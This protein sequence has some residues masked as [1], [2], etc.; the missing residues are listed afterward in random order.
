MADTG[1]TWGNSSA[2]S[3]GAG[4]SGITWDSSSQQSPQTDFTPSGFASQYSDAIS[5]AAS[6]LNVPAS[7]IA[8]QWGLET[9]WGKS[10]IPGTNNL[11]NLKSTAATGN[12]VAATDNATGS[13]DAYQQFQNPMD[14]S[15]AYVNLINKQYPKAVGAKDAGS[16]ATALKQGGYATDPNYVSSV[17][18]AANVANK[19]LAAVS[20]STSA[21]AASQD[22][23]A[24]ASSSV[25][26]FIKQVGTG[27]TTTTPS[28]SPGAPSVDDFI[29]QSGAPSSDNLGSKLQNVWSSIKNIPSEV[30]QG[31]SQS[32][33]HPLDAAKGVAASVWNPLINAFSGQTVADASQ[34]PNNGV[35]V[36]PQSLAAQQAVTQNANITPNANTNQT[37][38]NAGKFVGN[39]AVAGAVGAVAPEFEGASLLGRMAAPVINGGVQGGIQGGVT[40][41]MDGDSLGNVAAN[42]GLGAVGGAALGPV[43]HAIGAAVKPVIGA[44][45]GTKAGIAAADDAATKAGLAT[46]GAL[47]QSEKDMAG[48]VATAIN[49]DATPQTAQDVAA[50]MAANAN[51]TV[52][53]YQRT[54][55]ETTSNPTVQAIQQGLDKSDN[56]AGLA[57]QVDANANANTNFLR[58]GATS[59]ADLAAQKQSFQD[60]QDALANQGNA[61]MPPVS[62]ADAGPNGLFG[63][64]AMQKTLG[65]ANNAA[66]NDGSDA[67]QQAF[68]APNNAMAD[69]WSN[70]LAGSDAKTAAIES[71]RAMTTSPMYHDALSSAGPIA[72]DSETANLINT[73]AMQKALQGVETY[74]GNTLDDAPV[75]QNVP[76][77]GAGGHTYAQS[78]SPQDLNLAKMALDDHIMNMG[79]PLHIASAD[80]WQRGAYINLRNQVNAKLENHVPGFK[81]ANM[82]F[83]K[84]SDQM[85]ESQFLTNKNMV[86]ATGKMNV[87]Q[88]DA[89][90]KAIEAGK[91]NNNPH[92]PA[93]LVS[94]A[95]LAQ[96]QQMR[97]DAVSMMKTKSAEGLQGD[98]YNYL[99]QGAQQDPI[100]AQ[101]LQEHLASQ[102]PAYHQF[103]ND[104]AAGTHAI[105]QQEN[106]NN[107]VSKFDTRT[108]GNVSWHDTKNLGTDHADYSP[109]N[110]A[111]L[112]AVRANQERFANRT[113]QV[114]GSDT[115]SNFAKREGFQNLIAGQ[116]GNGI[117]NALMSESGQR[118]VRAGLGPVASVAGFSHAGPVGA[119]AADWLMDKAGSGIAKFA[120]KALGADTEEALAAKA[121]ANHGAVEKLLLNPK[122]LSDAISALDTSNKTKQVLT[123]SLISKVRGVQHLGGLL[124]AVSAGQVAA[125]SSNKKNKK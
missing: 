81:E 86:D 117:G 108:D 83:A 63:A 31:I 122:R 90:V 65:R 95:K 36:T 45:L 77:V 46:G 47:S 44:Y 121:A 12:G 72:L 53:G 112:N 115:A 55:A 8:G 111:R 48:K 16:F 74:K 26:S 105:G 67:I 23:T 100:A 102:S 18:S 52:P 58:Q 10:V 75:I 11:G 97:A 37:A 68:D 104:Q 119:V 21:N 33:Q 9:G 32:A 42:T 34:A 49:S 43:A 56:N 70:S 40:S 35:N 38:F 87:R 15:N 27:P 62:A 19:A 89:T 24:P 25:D 57:A 61:Q 125:N 51:S 91:A 5:N 4:S 30:G 59:D 106:Y 13:T 110:V 2:D 99:R 116:R 88:L 107:L 114:A 76:A 17:S 85:N 39:T 98:S 94:A 118:A 78:I 71:A 73:P 79:N 54:A 93:K 6:Q 3:S 29:K 82:E 109:E 22:S 80:K 123:D 84:R 113:E 7:A 28:V 92:D 60:S 20:G 50:E 103:Y 69:R 41:A 120:G 96:L 124:G 64:P 14:F 101:A 66:L 1:I